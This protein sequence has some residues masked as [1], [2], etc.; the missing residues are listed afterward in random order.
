MDLSKKHIETRDKLLKGLQHSFERLVK[1]A[2]HNNESLI[3]A[4]NGKPVK[5]KATDLLRE[6][7]QKQQNPV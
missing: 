5:V 3:M 7:E 6:L 2:A 4:H 1:T